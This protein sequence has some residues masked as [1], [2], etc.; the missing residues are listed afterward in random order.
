MKKIGILTF[1]RADNYGAVLQAYA[2]CKKLNELNMPAEIIDYHASSIEN[3]YSIVNFT[4][5]NFISK[6]KSGIKSFLIIHNTVAKRKHFQSFR[7]QHFDLSRQYTDSDIY[8]ADEMYSAIITGSDQVL[9]PD[10]TK[11]CKDNYTLA[12][13]KKAK[14][15]TYAASIGKR[16]LSKNEIKWLD[17]RLSS[18]S[19]ISF[20]EFS[21]KS[22]VNT[23]S[24]LKSVVSADPT[25][26]LSSSQWESL[27]ADSPA[28]SEYIFVYD[29]LKNKSLY[30]YALRLSEKKN[31]KVI[32][33]NDSLKMRAKYR[34]FSFFA[35]VPPE[36]FLSLIKHASYVLVSSFHGLV[37]SIIFKKM[38]LCIM[39]EKETLSDRL[40]S[41]IHYC[42]LENRYFSGT[43]PSDK[44]IDEEI[45]WSTVTKH[46]DALK[47]AS[48]SYLKRI[49]AEQAE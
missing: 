28:D 22:L 40:T 33:I 7:D 8:Q 14:K 38:F 36:M 45:D 21:S 4:G 5:K 47:T 37:F 26:L 13:A 39:P 6:M 1:H 17:A 2:L 30:D 42:S 18:F 32:C 46:L 43:I 12:F 24:T 23:P 25:L 20:R 27:I 31:M 19:G 41:L 3:A 48:E 16:D 10:I 35:S 49:G 15:Y 9:N 34:S 44:A 29:V 11:E